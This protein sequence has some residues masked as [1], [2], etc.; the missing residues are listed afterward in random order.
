M[1]EIMSAFQFLV[2]VGSIVIVAEIV[3]SAIWLPVYFRHGIRLYTRDVVERLPLSSLD[4][5]NIVA[6]SATGFRFHSLSAHDIGFRDPLVSLPWRIPPV[7]HGILTYDGSRLEVRGLV[8]WTVT[9][10]SIIFS[11]FAGLLVQHSLIY[12]AI[13]LA[14]FI[15]PLAWCYDTQRRRF[16]DLV[17]ELTAQFKVVT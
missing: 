9:A 16:D 12:T 11:F 7:M 6:C 10:V 3:A 17:V 14:G 4:L 2:G 1:K 13:V 15:A 5:M 8:N